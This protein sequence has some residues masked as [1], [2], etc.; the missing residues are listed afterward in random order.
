MITSF[1]GIVQPP[2]RVRGLDSLRF[3]AALWVVFA[4]VAWLP[5]MANLDRAEPFERALRG[6]W[7]NLFCGVAGVM[8][9]FVV[10]GFCIHYPH[11][12]GKKFQ[13][14]PF[15]TLRFL[16]IG[17]PLAGA[18]GLCWLIGYNVRGYSNKILWSLYAELIYY[19]IYPVVLLAIRSIGWKWLMA[20]AWAGA[21][22]VVLQNPSAGDYHVNGWRLTWLLGLPCW[23]MGCR[24]AE[25]V[26]K[27]MAMPEAER[28]K[29]FNVWPLRGAAWGTSAVASFLRFHTPL[30][31]PWTLNFFA[32][33]A[34]FWIHQEI[35]RYAVRPPKRI[36][37]WAGAWSYSIYLMHMPVAAVVMKLIGPD[38]QSYAVFG[39]LLVPLVLLGSYA[40]YL[41]VERPGHWLARSASKLVTGGPSGA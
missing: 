36:F 39:Y 11:V 37:E 8:V 4:H 17:I 5:I 21:A 19:A 35:R 34:K 20:I 16:R 33:F 14:L 23:L 2:R 22:Y 25:Q 30:G 15:Y 10:S 24:L 6:L 3:F 41:I 40:F 12:T 29:A 38:P 1:A 9:F 18:V 28:P 31:Y 7:G 13:L 32:I 27:E 26:A